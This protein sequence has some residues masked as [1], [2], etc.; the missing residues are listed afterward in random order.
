MKV[1][2]LTNKSPFPP[3]DGS[4]MAIDAMIRGLVNEGI[5]VKILA[6]N[7]PKHPK[8]LYDVP[9][10]LSHA[11]EI[12]MVD[13]DN[14]PTPFGAIKNLFSQDSY[15]ISRFQSEAFSAAVE[16]LLSKENFDW[17][18]VEG[19]SLAIY[20]PLIRKHHSGKI[21]NRAHN[22]EHLIW[23]RT[24]M[25]ETNGLKAAYIKLQ[26]KRLKQFELKVLN[27]FNAVVP[28]TPTDQA[29]LKSRGVHKPMHYAYCGINLKSRKIE[30]HSNPVDFFFVGSFD[31]QPNLQGMNWFLQQVWPLVLRKIPSAQ[32]H[33]LGRQ[34]PDSFRR[35]KGVHIH[36]DQ[37]T[38]ES[39]F[40]KHSILVVPLRSGSGLRIKIVE[41]MAMA[42]SIVT[43]PIGA[44]GI[45]GQPGVHFFI[46]NKAEDFAAAMIELHHSK[47]LRQSMGHAARTLAETYFNMDDIAKRLIE[48]MKT[49]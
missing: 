28:I 10:D 31:W 22:V 5:Q 49:L 40:E 4:S 38:A 6:M 42:K 23:E 25:Y 48:F 12:I 27:E 30:D 17:V 39:F 46:H 20:L 37:T 18:Q 43:T 11:I 16:G 14:R 33:I 35:I 26:A 13:V 7:T 36:P 44:E 21:V 1:A 2:F 41:A 15:I 8:S 3:N 19:L 24:A 32:L 29:L 47:S 9:N 45:Q 34:A